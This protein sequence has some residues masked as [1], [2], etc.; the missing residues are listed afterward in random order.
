MF[1]QLERGESIDAREIIGIFDMDASGSPRANRE[2]LAR[3]EAETGVISLY[4][5][6][7]RS[8]VLCDGEFGDRVYLTGLSTESV[9]KRLEKTR[10]GFFWDFRGNSAG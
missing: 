6:L 7:P 8:F 5:D 9:M 3:K 1:I 2:L 10:L 4:S